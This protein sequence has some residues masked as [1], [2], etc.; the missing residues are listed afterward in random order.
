MFITSDNILLQLD[1]I[2]CN[3][4]IKGTL[5]AQYSF[6]SMFNQ[7][8]NGFYFFTGNSDFPESI[9]NSAIIVNEDFSQSETQS[10]TYIYLN[11]DKD[12]QQVYYQILS[13]IHARKSNGKISKNVEIDSTVKIGKNVQIDP[14]CVIEEN[15]S[16]GDNTIIAS[17]VKIHKNTT[18]AD[19]VIIESGSIIGTQ[20]VAWI[21][22]EDQTKKIIQPQIGGVKIKS[23]SFLGAQTIIV[24]GSINENTIIGTN[25]LIAPGCR[26]GHGTFVDDYCHF[27][28]NIT[29]GGNVH[30]GKYSFIGSG[31]IFRPKVKLHPKTIVGAGALIIK[32][33]T[34]QKVTLIGVP[35]VE[36]ESSDKPSGMPK[37]KK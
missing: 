36:R 22:N 37:P 19:N 34:K 3:Y 16:I 10:N 26:F 9:D 8:N 12:P 6:A 35:A 25:C 18:I 21:W 11:S 14:F 31:A 17:N 15:V 7:I 30:I 2:G 29:T 27:A 32:N 23:N 33:T 1:E 13:N 20:G 4:K 5:K 24:R 28:N